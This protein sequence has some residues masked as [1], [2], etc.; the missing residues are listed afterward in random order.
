MLSRPFKLHYENY[1]SLQYPHI[2]WTLKKIT[3]KISDTEHT[4]RPLKDMVA[5][6]SIKSSDGK[7]CLE[8]NMW[9]EGKSHKFLPVDQIVKS[10]SCLFSMCMLPA[11][12]ILGLEFHLDLNS[13]IC[14]VLCQHQFI[15][16]NL[17]DTIS[18]KLVLIIKSINTFQ[19]QKFNEFYL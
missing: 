4:L 17:I 9:R 10:T 15:E 7:P 5:L 3:E 2:H 16:I 19:V 6:V 11:S 12:L 18:Y 14:S 13:A 1:I 8:Y